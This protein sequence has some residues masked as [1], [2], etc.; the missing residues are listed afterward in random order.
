MRF[1]E[2][3]MKIILSLNMKGKS[4]KKLG[5]R[6]RTRKLTFRPLQYTVMGKG[7]RTLSL[8]LPGEYKRVVHV[9]RREFKM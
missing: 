9:E 7:V 2:Y 6:N 4:C 3:E 5:R 8:P 1:K